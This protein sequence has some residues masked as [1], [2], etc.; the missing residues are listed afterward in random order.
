M[1]PDTTPGI[2]LLR[3]DSDFSWMQPADIY[4]TYHLVDVLAELQAIDVETKDKLLKTLPPLPIP[5]PTSG[6]IPPQ[7]DT[8]PGIGTARE[9]PNLSWI[10]PQA[11]PAIEQSL[12]QWEMSRQ[13]TRGQ[14]LRITAMLPSFKPEGTA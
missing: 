3:N 1:L 11:L 2:G 8:S 5:S 10:T 12:R 4:Q 6:E 13:I 7:G 14:S 9:K